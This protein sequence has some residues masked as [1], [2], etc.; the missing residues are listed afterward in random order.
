M[1]SRALTL[2]VTVSYTWRRGQKG[3]GPDHYY[4]ATP[5]EPDEIEVHEVELTED[6]Q[7]ELENRL[8]QLEDV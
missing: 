2:E 5:D 1:N 4:G 7:L 3:C 8:S 6:G